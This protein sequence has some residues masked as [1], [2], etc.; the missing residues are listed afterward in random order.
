MDLAATHQTYCRDLVARIPALRSRPELARPL[1][2]PV[3]C[4][5]PTR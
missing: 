5:S 2:Y 1:A 3:A 4:A